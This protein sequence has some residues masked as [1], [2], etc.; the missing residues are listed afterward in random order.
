[1]ATKDELQAALREVFPEDKA[2]R[3]MALLENWV[4][5]KCNDLR[6]QISESGPYSPDW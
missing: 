4:E 1:M 2:D 6:D 5:A 3:I